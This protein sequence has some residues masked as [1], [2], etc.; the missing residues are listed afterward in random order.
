VVVAVGHVTAKVRLYNP[1]D[2]SR[3]LELELLVDTGSTYTWVKRARL[4][5]LGLKPTTKWRFR[6]I[7]GRIVEREIGEAVAECLGERATTVVIFAEE[8]DAEVLGVHAMEGL[9]LE[10]DPATGQLRK[11]EALLA[12][13]NPKLAGV[14]YSL[15]P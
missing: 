9:R 14:S 8:G 10:V 13:A 2:L 4:E 3:R 6:T 12:L 15:A 1:E 11:A 5:G 7:E